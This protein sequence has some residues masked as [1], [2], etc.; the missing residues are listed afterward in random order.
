MGMSTLARS[1]HRGG[2]SGRQLVA[3]VVPMPSARDATDLASR[4]E[5]HARRSLPD[6][7]VPARIVLLPRL[8]M[9]VN[10][11]VDR[12]SLPEPDWTPRDGG[13]QRR[14]TRWS[15]SWP[16][17]GAMSWAMRASA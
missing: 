11:K 10:G 6:Y 14:K 16:A 2:A 12:R 9:T 7:M 13:A 1:W 4:I 3:Y 5:A 17:S 15:V 8:P